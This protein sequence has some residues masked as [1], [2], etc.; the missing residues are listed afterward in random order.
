MSNFETII[1]TRDDRGVA[2]VTLNRPDKHNALNAAMIG[3]LTAAADQ[4]AQ[5]EDVRL[6]VLAGAGRSFCAGGDLGWMRE[7]NE[8][9]RAGRIAEASRLAHMLAKLD[10][11]PQPLIA[12]VHGP[13]YGGGIGMI[14]SCD[15]AVVAGS[16]KFVLSETRLG[17][18]PATIGPFVLRALGERHARALFMNSKPFDAALAREIGLASIVVPGDALDEAVDREVGYVLDCAPGAVR[19]A[20][21][22]CLH[23]ARTPPAGQMD[24]TVEKL[25]ERWET[26]EAIEG[27]GSFL[28]RQKPSWRR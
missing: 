21:A 3:E 17:L 28:A 11:L 7:Q 20:K 26:A 13:A 8:A 18:I 15:I 4:L 23:L 22:L 25:A 1:L 19:D 9:T 27:I 10:A 5:D 6:V 2:T 24:W 14:C 16:A 12:R